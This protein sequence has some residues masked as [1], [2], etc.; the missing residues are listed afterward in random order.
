MT[1]CQWGLCNQPGLSHGPILDKVMAP[2]LQIQIMFCFVFN[3]KICRFFLLKRQMLRARMVPLN[4]FPSLCAGNMNFSQWKSTQSPLHL[5]FFLYGNECWELSKIQSQ[6][7]SDKYEMKGHMVFKPFTDQWKKQPWLT[8]QLEKP[9][10]SL[11]WGCSDPWCDHCKRR[12]PLA[13]VHNS[14]SLLQSCLHEWLL[15]SHT[16]K[17]KLLFPTQLHPYPARGLVPAGK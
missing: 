6:L 14:A 11:S 10:V 13:Q 16:R 2:I 12:E 9:S 17:S 7:V 3:T 5:S 15:K 1:Q 8:Q 4:N